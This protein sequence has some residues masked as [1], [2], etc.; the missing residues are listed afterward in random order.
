MLI[1]QEKALP[2]FL[3]ELKMVVIIFPYSKWWKFLY[4]T[5]QWYMT[6]HLRCR[7]ILSPTFM[8]TKT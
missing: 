3:M 5:K 7:T 2:C 6:L 1:P 4:S 8:D